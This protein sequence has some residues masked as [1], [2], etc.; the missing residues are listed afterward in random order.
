VSGDRQADA[1]GTSASPQSV[2][3]ISNE[4]SKTFFTEDRVAEGRLLPIRPFDDFQENLLRNYSF[5]CNLLCK[6][7]ETAALPAKP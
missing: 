4:G 1:G 5:Y 2:F 6:T 7:R 3:L